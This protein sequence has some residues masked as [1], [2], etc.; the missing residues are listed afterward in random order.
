[1]ALQLAFQMPLMS[2]DILKV[3][4]RQT[5]AWQDT[6]F[7]GHMRDLHAFMGPLPL[8]RTVS[9]LATVGLINQQQKQG[10]VALLG[11]AESH[12]AGGDS[13]TTSSLLI[14]EPLSLVE[15]RQQSG[16]TLQDLA[17]SLLWVNSKTSSGAEASTPST[18]LSSVA[19]HLLQAFGAEQLPWVD[20]MLRAPSKTNSRGSQKEISSY[21][22]LRSRAAKAAQW[23]DGSL[24]TA[25]TSWVEGYLRKVVCDVLETAEEEDAHNTGPAS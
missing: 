8:F 25:Y 18:Q 21:R 23:L 9:M 15:A 19:Q 14:E 11:G 16:I 6:A 20:L 10:M 22:Q 17:V 12:S 24:S 13:S 2:W 5:P 3:A 1:M 7:R 4:A